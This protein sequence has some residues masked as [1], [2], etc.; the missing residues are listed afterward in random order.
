MRLPITLIAPREFA[1]PE[2]WDKFE[3][4]CDAVELYGVSQKEVGVEAEIE[5]EGHAS[6]FRWAL[7]CALDKLVCRR[8]FL[9]GRLR[10]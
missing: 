10:A 6:P 9:E 8:I 7:L 3:R 1:S 2:E 4:K 5:A